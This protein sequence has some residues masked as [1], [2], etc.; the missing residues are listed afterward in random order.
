MEIAYLRQNHAKLF[1]WLSKMITYDKRVDAIFA[2]TCK[3]DPISY[4]KTRWDYT[5]E[6]SLVQQGVIKFKDANILVQR[7]MTL[8]NNYLLH[9]HKL[10]NEVGRDRAY[11]YTDVLE[12]YLQQTLER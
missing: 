2:E 9:T 12:T 5:K 8:Y 11:R 10:V 4:I 1:Y 3:N 6:I 7:Y